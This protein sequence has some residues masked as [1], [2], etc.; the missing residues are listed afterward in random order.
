MKFIP[1]FYDILAR[2]L[3]AKKNLSSIAIFT[4]TKALLYLWTSTTVVMWL[5]VL[6]CF[7]AY[8]NKSPVAWGGLIFTILHTLTPIVFKYTQSFSLSGLA[9][10]LTGLGFQTLFCLFSGGVFSPAAIWLT[11]HPVILGF[12]GSKRLITFSVV[13]NF[14]IVMM[15]Y[16][17][18]HYDLLPLNSLPPAFRDS[19]IISSYVGLDIL[20][21]VF[22]VTAIR[23]NNERN[24]E[25]NKSKELTE[26][27]LRILC[28]DIS[29]PLTIIRASS[30]H[31]NI[32]DKPQNPRSADRIRR[33]SEDIY[34]ITESVG[35]WI[36]HKDGKILLQV[37]KIKINDLIDHILFS[38]E[39]S[40]TNKELKINFNVENYNQEI[41]GDRTAIF[42]QI[43]N[44]IISNAIKFSYANST[45]DISF[46]SQEHFLVILIRD[47]GVGIKEEMIEKVFSPYD[48]TTSKGTRNERGT[49]FGLPIVAT[50]TDRLNGKISIENMTNLTNG[51]RGTCVK[52]LL[53]KA[54]N[55]K[56]DQSALDS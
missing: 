36:A 2:N 15:L 33:A 5:Y 17:L 41:L 19:M 35:S 44:N 9:I 45:I 18:G 12:F 50:V 54:M 38:F 32:E 1:N 29:N 52:L 40:L 56:A 31:L 51:E 11:L 53:P 20:V 27:L 4:K 25:L 39:D 16:L 49:G 37:Q 6:Y 55:S 46:F 43:I 28:H 3:L 42:Y 47:Y 10:S 22:T 8:G 13:L 21:A 30:K 7:M 23:I 48:I 26:N 24:E 14:I 34:R